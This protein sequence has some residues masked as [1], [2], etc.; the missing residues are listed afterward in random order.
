MPIPTSMKMR[1]STTRASPGWTIRSGALVDYLEHKGLREN[2][3]ILYLSDNGQGPFKFEGDPVPTGRRS[4]ST[5]FELGFRTP[6][7][8]NW[9][10]HVPAGVVR[11][12][13]VSTLDIVPTLMN[14]GGVEV[15]ESLTGLDIRTNVEEQTRVDRRQ[16]IGRA[17]GRIPGFEPEGLEGLK[18]KPVQAFYLRDPRWHYIWYQALDLELLFDLQQDAKERVNVVTE[19]PKLVAGFRSEI[20]TWKTAPL[21]GGSSAAPKTD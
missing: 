6:I 13:L 7:V 17:R 1:S 2:T 21:P 16:I 3:L 4:K 14:Y 15:P 20:E 11:E 12:D 10:G 8:F 9:P 5:L 19:H 18:W